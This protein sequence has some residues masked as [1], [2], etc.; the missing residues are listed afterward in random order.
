VITQEHVAD[1]LDNALFPYVKDSP[2]PAGAPAA[3]M[4]SAPVQT[5]SLRSQKP[6]WH[7]AARPGGVTDT[8]Q[9]VLVFMAGG[10]TYSEIREAYQ[11]SVSLN[12][13]IYIGATFPL[14]LF[15]AF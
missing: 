7:K 10:M 4:R 5:T 9:R 13:D 14:M 1:K 8:R 15:S 6:I 11:L 12:K 3:S 2:T